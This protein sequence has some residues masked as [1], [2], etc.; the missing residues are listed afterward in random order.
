MR[1][2]NLPSFMRYKEQSAR[3]V[4]DL[5]TPTS[6]GIRQSVPT[7][8]SLGSKSLP[9]HGA[10]ILRNTTGSSKRDAVLDKASIKDEAERLLHSL[11]DPQSDPNEALFTT[12][13]DRFTRVDLSQLVSE[14]AVPRKILQAYLSLLQ[15]VHKRRYARGKSTHRLKLFKLD[16]SYDIFNRSRAQSVH[17]AENIFTL[18]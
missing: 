18:E 3:T 10:G 15:K 13:K 1:M 5:A 2:R 6:G 4:F 8:G 12:N 17:C 11:S 9:R 14:D 16:L 7:L